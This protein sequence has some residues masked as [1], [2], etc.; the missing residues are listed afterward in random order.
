MNKND[1]ETRYWHPDYHSARARWR[2]HFIANVQGLTLR[3]WLRRPFDRFG[4]EGYF[5]AEEFSTG[6]WAATGNKNLPCRF[7]VEKG[8][9]IRPPKRWNSVI[10]VLIGVWCR[11]E[12]YGVDTALN[13]MEKH[14]N[15]YHGVMPDPLVSMTK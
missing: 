6:L 12:K 14:P 3:V 7:L 9:T 2:Q 5:F 13:E 15:R 10:G 11:C 4:G 8:Y 1:V